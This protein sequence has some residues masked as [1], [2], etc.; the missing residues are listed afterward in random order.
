MPIWLVTTIN[1]LTPDA[2][3]YSHRYFASR[4][5]LLARG[6][7]TSAFEGAETQSSIPAAQAA[8]AFTAAQ[9]AL[10]NPATSRALAA[11]IQRAGSAVSGN[12]SATGSPP[13][14]L[15]SRSASSAAI[16]NDSAPPINFGRVAAA[17]QA[18]SAAA[19]PPPPR[20]ANPPTHKQ[21][22]PSTGLVPQK[23][24]KCH[25]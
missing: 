16:D 11:G 24:R 14:V 2:L 3:R 20:A 21:T 17:A 10:A 22:D 9:R 18:F 25:L 23:V 12:T 19:T 6:G 8:A 15:P 5:D 1:N 4:P 13:P 7:P